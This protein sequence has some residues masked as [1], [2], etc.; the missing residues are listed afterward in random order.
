MSTELTAQALTETICCSTCS[1]RR[2]TWV[3][4]EC[5]TWLEVASCSSN[6]LQVQAR[7]VHRGTQQLKSTRA[8]SVHCTPDAP[9]LTAHMR[10]Q[11]L[12]SLTN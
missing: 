3:D 9:L 10:H 1:N 8:R 5:P 2:S 7:A 4:E 6:L 11:G 12:Y